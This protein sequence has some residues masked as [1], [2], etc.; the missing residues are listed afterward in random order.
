MS[1][2]TASRLREALTDPAADPAP[3]RHRRTGVWARAV[4]KDSARGRVWFPLDGIRALAAVVVIAYHAWQNQI[5]AALSPET[6]PGRLANVLGAGAATAVTLFLMVSGFLLFRP[7]AAQAL[8]NDRSISPAGLLLRRVSRLYPLYVVTVLVMWG[9][10]NPTV[11]GHWQD[12]LLHLTFTQVYSDHYIFWTIGP[13]WTLAVEFHFYLVLALLIVPVARGTARLG[14]RWARVAFL[15][16]PGLAFVAVGLAWVAYQ[17]LVR[18][19]PTDDWSVW[20]SP[21]TMA[22]SFG[23]GM[24]LAIPSALNRSLPSLLREVMMVLAVVWVAV[25]PFRVPVEVIG[26]SSDYLWRQV[27]IPAAALLLAGLAL[28]GD[29]PSRLLQLRPLVWVGSLSYGVYLLHEPVLRLARWSGLL[30]ARD[31][32]VIDIVP[33]TVVV[34]SGAVLL[35][36]ISNRVLENNAARFFAQFDR[37]GRPREYYPHLVGR[38]EGT[39]R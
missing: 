28:T 31:G 10:S 17:A 24:L 12:L 13:S 27:L 1:S 21:L 7:I 19:A 37:H 32:D 6:Q 16:L 18:E 25:L 22:P 29:R 23:V 36:W 34:M 3:G 9:I 33:V 35:A 26:E 11:P 38:T 30:P 20:F 2:D 8:E 5:G 15:A 4:V 39:D 14:N